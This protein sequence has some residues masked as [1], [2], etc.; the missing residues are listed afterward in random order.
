[1]LGLCRLKSQRLLKDDYCASI[2]Q[3]IGVQ[4][5]AGTRLEDKFVAVKVANLMQLFPNVCPF[6]GTA[7]KMK[8]T[9]VVCTTVF[10]SSYCSPSA[11]YAAFYLCRQLVR[12]FESTLTALTYH[13]ATRRTS[14]PNVDA[15]AFNPRSISS[16]VSGQR[17]VST[18]ELAREQLSRYR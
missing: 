7:T 16:N 14:T 9:E 11:R 17:P 5:R 15:A 18:L 4:P 13:F 10:T 1:M 3:S 12:L 6:C 8:T 2:C